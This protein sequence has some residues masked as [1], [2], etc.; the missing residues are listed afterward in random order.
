MSATAIATIEKHAQQIAAGQAKVKPGQPFRFSEAAQS[1]DGVWQGDLGICLI[2]KVPAGMVRVEKPSEQDKQLVPGNTQGSQHCL[3]SLDGVTIYRPQA[4]PASA[5]TDYIGPCLV[6]HT[7][8]TILH[9]KHGPVT[10]LAGSIVQCYYQREYD[11]EQRLV[12]RS[13]D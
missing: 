2:D 8:V 10:I 12:R 5:E 3:E 6:A 7:D 9:P 13:L 1:G 4:W 11:A